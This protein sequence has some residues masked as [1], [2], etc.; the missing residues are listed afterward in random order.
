MKRTL[1]WI[2]VLLLLSSP[3]QA[4]IIGTG[5]LTAG[6]ADCS[7][8]ARCAAFTLPAQTA[9]LTF[10]VSGTFSATLQFEGTADGTNWVAVMAVNLADGSSATSTAAAGQ[11]SLNNSGLTAVRVRASAYASGTA[12]VTAVRGWSLARWLTPFFRSLTVQRDGLATTSTDGIAVQNTT[13]ATLA[14]PVQLSPRIRQSGTGWDAD[15]TVTRTVSFFTEALPVSGNT[16]TATWKLGFVAADGTTVTYPLTVTSGG[17]V[18]SLSS[19]DAGANA[20]VAATGAFRF[21]SDRSVVRAPS[22]GALTVANVGETNA[23]TITTADWGT[24]LSAEAVSYAQ[25]AT[26]NLAG[27]SAG[28]I[29]LTIGTANAVCKFTFSGSTVAESSDTAY[30][31]GNLCTTTANN[32]A[33]VNFYYDTDHYVI[34]NKIAGTRTIR[35]LVKGS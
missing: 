12:T 32:A 3:A 35:A 24:T 22:D 18:T 7:V 15:N 1:F 27:L 25:D 4:Q 23:L 21:G 28:E 9:S 13:A 30:D 19:I 11:F 26:Q 17:I 20:S 16:V 6:G 29:L 33:T 8:V 5:S 10:Q 31:A 14:V 34:Q 2:A